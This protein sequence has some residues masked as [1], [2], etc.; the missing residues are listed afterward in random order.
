MIKTANM[1]CSLLL[2]NWTTTAAIP[3]MVYSNQQGL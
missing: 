3:Y 1:L 2:S